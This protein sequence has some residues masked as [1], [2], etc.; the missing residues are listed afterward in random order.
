MKGGEKMESKKTVLLVEDNIGLND[1][2]SQALKLR[3]YTVLTAENL[4]QAR[5]QLT[6][7]SPDVILLDVMLPDGSGFDFCNEIRDKTK[8]YII[9]L[10]AR[11]TH[12]D[13]VLGITGGGDSYITKPFHPEEML[14]KV[15]AAVRRRELEKAAVKTHTFANMTLDIVTGQAFI[16]GV[17]LMLTKKEFSL[18][19]VFT[20]NEGTLLSPDFLFKEVWNLPFFVYDKTLRRHISELRGKLEAGNCKYTVNAIYSKGYRFELRSVQ[21]VETEV[22]TET[23]VEV[24]VEVEVEAEN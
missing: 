17:D 22:E 14:V 15:D 2:N 12:E 11:T 7:V 4:E 9:F 18:L 8:A 21:E 10:T 23:E 13:M 3:G 5:E 1:A 16:D 20:Q 6:Q 19:L 24:E